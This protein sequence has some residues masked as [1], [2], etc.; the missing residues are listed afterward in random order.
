M[1]FGTVAILNP[2]SGRGMTRQS[3]ARLIDL[4]KGILFLSEEHIFLTEKSGQRTALNLASYA[5]KGGAKR[6]VVFGGDGTLHQVVNGLSLPDSRLSVGIVPCGTSNV[7]ASCLGMPRDPKYCLEIISDNHIRQMDL[8]EL[9]GNGLPR[10]AVFTAS[11]GFDAMINEIAHRIKPKLRRCHLPSILGYVPPLLRYVLYSAP[12]YPIIIQK[13]GQEILEK[14]SFLTVINTPR[15]GGGMIVDQS[16][17][18]DDGLFSLLYARRIEP[19]DL[20]QMMLQMWQGNH[21]RHPRFFSPCFSFSNLNVTSE[22]PIPVQVDGEVV[23]SQRQISISVLPRALRV[24]SPI[25]KLTEAKNK[26][27]RQ[28]RLAP[29]GGI[30]SEL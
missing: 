27:T 26:P 10:Y 29:I 15:Y 24:I 16:A 17:R 18:M 5:Q 14:V 4:L 23:L 13:D 19:L 3:L 21:A 9:K 25:P 11:I 2:A 12:T 28:F 6:I 8:G 22:I 1:R 20:P 30:G 7:V